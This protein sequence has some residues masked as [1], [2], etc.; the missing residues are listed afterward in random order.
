[1]EARVDKKINKLLLQV[2]RIGKE[3]KQ[4]A[5]SQDLFSDERGMNIMDSFS[6]AIEDA[7]SYLEEIKTFP[8]NNIQ[9]AASILG[10]IKTEKKARSSAENGKKGGRPRKITS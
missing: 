10:S 8:D 7:E 5:I 2:I 1:M 3:L 4:E 6:I 9:S